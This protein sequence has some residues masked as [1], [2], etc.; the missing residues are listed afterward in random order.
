M[1]N[2]AWYK[3]P[4]GDASFEIRFSIPGRGIYLDVFCLTANA[5]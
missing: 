5:S 1:N 4:H 3:V 2:P